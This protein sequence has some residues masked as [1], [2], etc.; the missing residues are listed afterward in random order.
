MRVPHRA[1]RAVH[2][3]AT[4][5]RR[6]ARFGV[7]GVVEEHAARSRHPRSS[8]EPR[9]YTRVARRDAE[10]ENHRAQRYVALQEIHRAHVPVL[11]AE[12]RHQDEQTDER[13]AVAVHTR[14]CLRRRQDG[15]V[16]GKHPPRD[17]GVVAKN[18]DE[19]RLCRVRGDQIPRDGAENQTHA[20][21]GGLDVPPRRALDGLE[22]ADVT[23]RARAATTP[24]RRRRAKR[25][26]DADERLALLLQRY[27]ARSTRVVVVVKFVTRKRVR[28]FVTPI[29]VQNT[30]PRTRL[31]G[32]VLAPRV[33]FESALRVDVLGDVGERRANRGTRRLNT[34]T[35]AIENDGFGEDL[36]EA[37][38]HRSGRR[39]TR[40]RVQETPPVA[41]EERA[42]IVQETLKRGGAAKPANRS[43]E[44]VASSRAKRAGAASERVQ[45]GDDLRVVHEEHLDELRARRRLAGRQ[46]LHV[47]EARDDARRARRADAKRRRRDADVRHD[48]VSW[49]QE[50]EGLRVLPE[51]VHALAASQSGNLDR[52]TERGDGRHAHVARER[53][54]AR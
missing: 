36:V 10:E 6:G 21:R 9:P 31:V 5:S 27:L 32:P 8:L 42:E 24:R 15:F 22:R 39:A 30:V 34:H 20:R 4:G 3:N 37:R 13:H 44:P 16:R 38:A 48:T 35:R 2:G 40:G 29:V 45:L 53:S 49:R 7:D 18:R 12:Q 17:G 23:S 26:R 43:V 51:D 28:L 14:S 41:L 46:N 11:G 54:H 50:G 19:R 25:S 1:P 33:V 52:V 47:H